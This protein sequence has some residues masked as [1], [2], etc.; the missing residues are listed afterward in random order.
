VVTAK[1]ED[2]DLQALQ[3]ATADRG[4]VLGQLFEDHR[5]RLKRM[6][7][8]R[9]DQALRARVGASDVVQETYVEVSARLGTYLDD[10]RMPFFLWLR[11]LTAQKLVDLYRHHVGTQKRDP[12]RQVPINRGAFP[13]ASS[14]VMANEL[15]GSLTTPSG[16]AVR[17]EMRIQ[18]QAGLDRMNETDREVLMMRHFEQLSNTETALELGIAE[19]AASKRYLRALQRLRALLQAAGASGADA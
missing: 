19:S 16:A 9:M 11:L 10:P 2:S 3:A 1:G 13:G 6:V 4:V 5:A 15:L 8:L 14:V 12:R 7:D 17:D 18:V